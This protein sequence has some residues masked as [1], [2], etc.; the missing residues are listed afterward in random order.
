MMPGMPGDDFYIGW[1]DPP[2]Q[3]VRRTLVGATRLLLALAAGLAVLLATVQGPLRGGR[4]EFGVE[5]EFEGVM[6]ER[7]APSLRVTRPGR[8]EGLDAAAVP[9][10]S[11][12]L[13]VAQGKHGAQELVAG[14]D[15]RRV[16]AR[17][18][19]VYRDGQTLL[20]LGGR[21]QD[22]D[23]VAAAVLSIAPPGAA[24]PLPL[25]HAT[26]RGEIVDSKCSFGVMVPGEGRAHRACAIRCLSGGIPPVFRVRAE[27]GGE[28]WLLLVG[29][30]GRALNR[31]ILDR[32]AEPLQITGEVERHDDLLVLRAEPA[33]FVSAAP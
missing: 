18:S 31:E 8:I 13:L 4:F 5:R 24:A 14:L 22:L 30:D 16:R 25:G 10:V 2:P 3:S 20:E 19:L 28:L 6:S 26:L 9:V 21:P 1:Q 33:E 29:R 12:W 32:V 7:P 23:P 15:G 11:R 17:G 27:E